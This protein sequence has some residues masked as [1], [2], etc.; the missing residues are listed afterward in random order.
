MYFR[1]LFMV[2]ALVSGIA[3]PL[4]ASAASDPPLSDSELSL[5]VDSILAPAEIKLG[6]TSRLALKDDYQRYALW[7]KY[8]LIT[9]RESNWGLLQ[10]S[11][12][13]NG[14]A[15]ACPESE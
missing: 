11:P 14:Q 2:A 3:Q 7:A 9:M 5:A 15:L 12:T 6:E 10:V 4:T 8:G 1:Y 13:P